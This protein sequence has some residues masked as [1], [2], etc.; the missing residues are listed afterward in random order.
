MEKLEVRE[1]K[2]L[3][4]KGNVY[5]KRVEGGFENEDGDVV[6]PTEHKHITKAFSMTTPGDVL[7]FQE[8]AKGFDVFKLT[9]EEAAKVGFGD[10]KKED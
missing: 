9:A 8:T 7:L 10:T 3:T 4:I 2:N 1:T 5:L 6:K